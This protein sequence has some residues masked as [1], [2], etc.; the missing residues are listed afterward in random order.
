MASVIITRD[1]NI[2]QAVKN[3]LEQIDLQK[4][5]KGKLVA[6]KPNETYA[7][8]EDKTGV[9]Q[10]DTL[11]RRRS[12]LRLCIRRDRKP[13]MPLDWQCRRLCPNVP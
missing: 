2:E 10:P 4:L 8:A 12:S 5:I 1:D 6:V 9:T 11:R 13:R 7:T 3:A